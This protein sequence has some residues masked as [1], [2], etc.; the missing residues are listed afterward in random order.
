MTNCS[1]HKESLKTQ[2]EDEDRESYEDLKR[3]RYA[4][5]VDAEIAL[6]NGVSKKVWKVSPYV[7]STR[8]RIWWLEDKDIYYIAE[9]VWRTYHE[10]FEQTENPTEG[11]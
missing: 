10:Y 11:K 2:Y 9:Y 5:S 7:K 4:L 6:C 1:T 8:D 3:A